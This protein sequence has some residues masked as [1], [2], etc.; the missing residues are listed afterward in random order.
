MNEVAEPHDVSA[1]DWQERLA[2]IVETMR[3][4]SRQTDPQA[5]VRAYGTRMR[6]LM[7]TDRTVSLSR[8]DLPPPKYRITRSSLWKEEVNPWQNKDRLPVLEGG[9]LGELIYGDEPRVIDEIQI[10]PD[11]PAAE[12]FAGMRSLIAVPDYNQGM[13]IN[14]VV[15]RR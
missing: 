7:Q 2:F 8:R 9:L 4:M 3:D 11:D 1:G 10:A 15:L 6:Q 12:Y 14:R 13:A 5:M